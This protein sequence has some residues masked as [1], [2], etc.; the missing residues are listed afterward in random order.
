MTTLS[1]ERLVTLPAS[2]DPDDLVSITVEEDL[3]VFVS[4]PDGKPLARL[5]RADKALFWLGPAPWW[6]R[7]WAAVRGRRTPLVWRRLS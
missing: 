6:A 1:T 7:L 2:G 4:D 5:A 3:F